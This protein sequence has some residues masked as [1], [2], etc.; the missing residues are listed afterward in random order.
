VYCISSYLKTAIVGL[1]DN[2]NNVVWTFL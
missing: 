2:K 1:N